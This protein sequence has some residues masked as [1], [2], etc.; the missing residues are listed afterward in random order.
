MRISVFGEGYKKPN[1]DFAP[2][3]KPIENIDFEDYIDRVKSGY[4][5]DP[6]LSVRAGRWEK[7]RAPYVTP[8][9]TF[10]YRNIKGLINHSGLI[11]IDIDKKDNEEIHIDQISADQYVFALHQS[12]SGNGGYALYIKIEPERHYDAF[13]GLEKYFANEYQIIIDP[14]CKDVSRMRFVSHDPE[15]II[16]KG[17]KVFKKYLTKKNVEP[18]KTYVH[19]G[20]DIS[21][22]FSQIKDRS[23][24]ICE[25]YHD[26]VK[27]GMAF[28]NTF[29]E[30]GRDKFHFVSSFSAKYSSESTDK[31]YTGFL[32]R[33][34]S[35]N[36]I[37][38]IFF[39]CQQ[40]GI[41]IK[42]P[43]TENIER[44]AKIRRKSGNGKIKDPK[45]DAIKTLESAG[46]SREE[47][48]PI[49]DQVMGMNESEISGEKTDD[50]I[51][52]LKAFLLQYNI[53]FNEITRQNEIN[54]LEL[55]DR[56]YNSLYIKSKEIV[57]DK[58]T[59]DL[60]FSIID[61]EFT[62]SYNPFLRFFEKNKHL[63]PTGVIQELI[64]CIQY[65]AKI[66]EYH[67][68]NY[69]HVYMVNW[70]LSCVS[71]AHG[72]YSV[73]VLVL[74]GAQNEG[75][76]KF[77]RNL[78][79]DPLLKYYGESKLDGGSDDHTLMCKK[80]IIMDDEFGGKNK[81]EA[82]KFKDL[83][84]KQI[85]SVRK[86]YGKFHEDLRRI[87]VLCGTSNEDD[88]IND[89]T[90]NRRIIPVNVIS[91][92]WE[93]YDSIDKTALWMELYWKWKEIGDKWM[94]TKEQIKY[95]N[96][97][98]VLNEVAST[99][100]EA[101][102][103]FFELPSEMKVSQFMSSTEIINWIETRTKLKLSP[104]K[105]GQS[106]KKL[107][108][109]KMSKRRDDMKLPMKLYEVAIKV[110]TLENPNF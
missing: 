102:L 82:K 68:D 98:T 67:I 31:S 107:G 105:L 79:P 95:L 76:T 46:I 60:L 83:T 19:T 85:F 78:L 27:V 66:G 62:P 18:R 65:E 5:E 69:L 21:F 32:K 36:S 25:D 10:D 58:V 13:L 89:P 20:D 23:I 41:K 47:S 7:I 17:A 72:V 93:K 70:L 48:E 61:S 50:L 80:L 16:I 39:L 12:I 63:K 108:F 92:D 1:G 26:W 87:A 73:M 6:V 8:S 38:S 57:S 53:E 35:E 14:A 110:T 74:S 44:I 40:Q 103:M 45:E 101:I 77:F 24:N 97:A 90:G 49:V 106:L 42:T 33:S 52:D 109:V 9:G 22:I 11:Q 43:K 2:Q 64:E 37:G 54:G 99:E 84:A 94:L 104:T 4:W 96:D 75:K 59:K 15:A 30:S 28:A 88:I 91:I 100:E 55:D 51:Q 34:R 81:L 3:N 56:Q 71:S 86:P 29:G